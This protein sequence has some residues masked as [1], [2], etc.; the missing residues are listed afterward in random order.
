M[1]TLSDGPS[2]GDGEM[3]SDGSSYNIYQD[4]AIF[5]HEGEDNDWFHSHPTRKT[6]RWYLMAH[7]TFFN[8]LD[9]MASSLLLFLGFTEKPASKS[10]IK[11]DVLSLPVPVHGALEIFSLSIIAFE[12]GIKIR[13]QGVKPS[14]THKRTV[15]K[16]II[17]VVMYTEAII[18]LVRRE[19]HFRV[20]RA[21]RPLFLID[22]HYC[23]GVRRVLRE[24]LLSLPPILDVLFLL[25]FVM[26]SF[27]F[28]GFFLFSDNEKDETHYEKSDWSRA[29]NQFTIACELDVG[30]WT[31]QSNVRSTLLYASETWRPNKKL[32]SKLRGFEGRCLRRILK[33][34]WQE[35][36]SNEEIWRRTGMN[37]IVLEVKRR[38]WT[39][40]GHVL[41]MK[42]G[43]H[44]LEALSWVPPGKRHRGRP[45]GGGPS[46]TR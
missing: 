36:V 42:K 5:L 16:V 13:W 22:A 37:N 3:N 9:L 32:E 14:F 15:M 45:L 17:L 40:L 27:A 46:R 24:I 41:C 35:K 1:D 34:R 25:L 38:R 6:I 39:W 29:F 33:V 30:R 23:N 20:S 28:L 31:V 8:M 11:E 26:F 10:V 44:P 4:A 21:L 18:V 43:R 12:L 2:T 19:N 7:S